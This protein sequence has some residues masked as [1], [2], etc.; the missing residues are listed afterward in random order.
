[1]TSFADIV[2]DLLGFLIE[3]GDIIVAAIVAIELWL[4]DQLGQLGVSQPIQTVILVALAVFL[5]FG[6]LR[7]FGGLI[8]VAAVLVLLLIAIHIMMPVFRH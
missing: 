5:I 8:R 6:S 2:N 7:I 3:L 1:M 4:R